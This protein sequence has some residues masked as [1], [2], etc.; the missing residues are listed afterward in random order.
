MVFFNYATM[1]MAAKIVYYGPG[2]CGKTTNLHHIYAKTSPQSRGEMVSLETE[3]DR[4]LFF[5]LLPI[6]V[7]VIGGFKTRLQLYTIPGQVF[8]NTTRKLVL[9][10]VDGLVFV[11]D[12]QVAM[13]DANLESF[14]NLREN[15]GEI[16][17]SVDEIP[18]VLQINKRDLPNIA[19][20]ETVVDVI[21]PEHKYDWVEAVASRGDGVFETLKV[22]SKLT[23]RTLRRRMTGEEPVRATARKPADSASFRV[24]D[25][26][27]TAAATIA[28]PAKPKS[29]VSTAPIPA[30]GATSAPQTAAPKAAAG[31]VA[32]PPSPIAE[33]IADLEPIEE[34]S[35]D[36]EVIAEI[37]PIAET[38]RAQPPAA[39]APEIAPRPYEPPAAALEPEIDFGQSEKQS[40]G[41]PDVKHVKVRSSV[42][43]MAEL[44]SLR[45]RA[46]QSSPKPASKK[47][48]SPLDALRH[49]PKP[50]RDIHRTVTL[51]TPAGTL[52]KS[53]RLRVTVSFEND[54]G[55]VQSQEE[56][57]DLGDTGDVQSLSVNLKFEDL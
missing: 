35:A 12:S 40:K 46:T 31:P 55:V 44:E 25:E 18:L 52:P 5:D 7:G 14:K 8:Y 22:I 56:S 49:P 27:A 33:P 48:V 26:N 13:L 57:I 28:A 6:D 50:K 34:L 41:A 17:L 30:F 37:P 19:P 43:I 51:P 45:K 2:L 24:R 1:Q 54:G 32:T 16:G 3:T 47:E 20:V 42:D 29:K 36:D 11:A 53:K 38:A 21:D 23:L 4:T 39:P 15:L 10:G 9:K